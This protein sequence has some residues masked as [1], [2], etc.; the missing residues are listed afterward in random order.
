M[1]HLFQILDAKGTPVPE[2]V[3]RKGDTVVIGVFQVFDPRK[4]LDII[5]CNGDTGLTGNGVHL[6][7]R[8]HFERKGRKRNHHHYR[9]QGNKFFH[10][11]SLL[12]F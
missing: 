3:A 12:F 6:A 4:D 2:G 5:H 10:L 7:V 9:S 11:L 1:G 8:D